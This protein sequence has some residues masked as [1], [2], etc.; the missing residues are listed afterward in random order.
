MSKPKQLKGQIGLFDTNISN[1]ENNRQ[2]QKKKSNQLIIKK[3]Y[4]Y[5]D[6]TISY[7]ESALSR[8]VSVK[9]QRAEDTSRAAINVLQ[10][11]KDYLDEQS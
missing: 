7:Y 10:D 6:K 11:L 5:I 4:A 3:M 8:A 2:K 9:N 1:D